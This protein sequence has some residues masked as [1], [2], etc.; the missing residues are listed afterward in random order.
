MP[1]MDSFMQRWKTYISNKFDTF[2]HYTIH[3]IFSFPMFGIIYF[4]LFGLDK[5][6]KYLFR[7]GYCMVL[8]HAIRQKINLKISA[9]VEPYH[10]YCESNKYVYDIIGRHDRKQFYRENVFGKFTLIRKNVDQTY[11]WFDN[12]RKYLSIAELC[13]MHMIKQDILHDNI[14]KKIESIYCKDT[15]AQWIVNKF[16]TILINAFNACLNWRLNKRISTNS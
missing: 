13:V 3:W 5:H 7:Y 14:P 12:C 9:I 2:Y 4:H 10:V 16:K 15:K 11:Y 8:A 1:I 6:V